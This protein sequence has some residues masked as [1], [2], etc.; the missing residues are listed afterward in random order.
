MFSVLF[1]TLD[2]VDTGVIRGLRV[3][4]FGAGEGR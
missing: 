2:M 3:G 1:C 4:G